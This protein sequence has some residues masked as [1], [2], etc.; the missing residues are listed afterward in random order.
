[1]QPM[2]L[3]IIITIMICLLMISVS[4]MISKK[5]IN[6]RMK[7]SPFECGFNPS[8]SPRLP[9]SIQFFMISI[10]FLIFDIEISIILPL[11][12]SFK[13]CNKPAWILTVTVF[14]IILII[15][16]LY[17]WHQTLLNWNT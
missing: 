1:M 17:E 9:F 13:I 2:N 7:L 6:D 12:T 4:L 3:I 15:G 8:S 14:M 10:V 11:I 16:I 5:K